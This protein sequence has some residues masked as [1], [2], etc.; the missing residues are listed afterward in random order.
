MYRKIWSTKLNNYVYED[1]TYNYIECSR[2][3]LLI[4]PN[5][6]GKS[7][8]ARTLMTSDD[9]E[10]FVYDKNTANKLKEQ[11]QFI[12]DLYQD[13]ITDSG[14]NG[15]VL[16]SFIKEKPFSKSEL[17]KV[18]SAIRHLIIEA[19]DRNR[20]RSGGQHPHIYPAIQ[21][22]VRDSGYEI[23]TDE[24]NIKNKNQYYIPIL[25]G[26]RPLNTGNND[27]Y[28][29]RTI[30][31]YFPSARSDLKVIT[32]HDIYELLASHLLGQPEQ[33][34]KIKK[35]EKLLSSEFFNGEEVTLG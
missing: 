3:N 19:S 12:L 13:N 26:M 17:N 22:H 24:L 20:N 30:K 31:D 21:R 29:E 4:G 14:I 9:S 11:Y 27:V 10:L 18:F 2:L 15:N 23:P 28:L 25:R 6:S 8:F 7:R 5:N 32:G 1:D 33:R 34:E 35:Y 16:Q